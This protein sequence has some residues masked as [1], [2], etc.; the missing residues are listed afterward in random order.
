MTTSTWGTS[1]RRRR[2][3]KEDDDWFFTFYQPYRYLL[4]HIP[5][6]PSVGN[7]DSSD[8]EQSDDRS[9]LSDNFFLD[10]R[11]VEEAGAERSSVDPG[12][13]YSFCFGREAN[14]G[15]GH[16]QGH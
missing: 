8:K 5:V 3:A 7:H 1:P 6:Y 10:Q 13:F 14:S 15:G 4:D 2:P 16:L 12:L 9:Q 11:F